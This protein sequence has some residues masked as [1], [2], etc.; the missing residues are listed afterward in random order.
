LDEQGGKVVEVNAGPGLQMHVWPERG[1]PRPVGEAILSTLFQP[2][3]TG[4]V[5]IVSV[6]GTEHT[7]AVSRLIARMLEQAGRNVGLACAEGVFVGERCNKRGD[8]RSAVD[9]AGLLVHPAVDAAVC[10]ASF[11]S[12]LTEAVAFDQC[13]VAVCLGMGEGLKLDFAEWDS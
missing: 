3:Q 2:E 1:K 7:L 5:P 8:C 4:R 12:I 11:D 6:L 13:D 9:V 10:E